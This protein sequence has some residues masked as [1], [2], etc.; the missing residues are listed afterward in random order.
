MK[1]LVIATIALSLSLT[2]SAATYTWTNSTVNGD[3]TNRF[4]WDPAT[5]FP[6][7][8]GDVIWLVNQ[9][10]GN[11]DGNLNIYNA[12]VTAGVIIAQGFT[13]AY[14]INDG[15]SGGRVVF[16]NTA[17]NAQ[18]VVTNRPLSGARYY[19]AS[20]TGGTRAEFLSDTD[21]EI[22]TGS[23]LQ[24]DPAWVGSRTITKTGGG[25]LR[26]FNGSPQFTGTLVI[27]AGRAWHRIGGTSPLTNATVIIRGSSGSSFTCDNSDLYNRFII[28]D[29]A[30]LYTPFGNNLARSVYGPVTINTY[31]QLRVSYGTFCMTAYRGDINGNGVAVLTGGNLNSTN[32]V[33]GSVSPGTNNVGILTLDKGTCT[34]ELGT[35][36]DTVQLNVDVAGT[37]GAPGIDH[38]LLIVS[39]LTAA[40][41]LSLVDLNV[42]GVGSGPVTNWVLFAEDGISNGTAFASV[43]H[44]S[45]L[46]VNAV[47]D[48]DNS[49]AGIIVV[50]E[51]AVML[52][53]AGAAALL[54]VRRQR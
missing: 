51:P 16:T 37:G 23:T 25:D 7:E 36:G 13:N 53:I 48:Y 39:N 42:S 44:A 43:T 2:A 34:L 20:L 22:E 9:G 46:T 17:G 26:G 15:Y 14:R 47:Y 12:A 4:N 49:L 1:Y 8:P 5:S 31:G 18:I 54:A 41:D 52:G 40:L 33:V 45:G 30:A 27:Q 32:V 3:W 50:P 6:S 19:Q 28:E 24:M 10:L 29:N 35:P 38:D 21:I 11:V